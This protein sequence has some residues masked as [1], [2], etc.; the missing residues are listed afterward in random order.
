MRYSGMTLSHQYGGKTYNLQQVS[1]RTAKKAYDEG[2]IVFLQ[3]CNMRFGNMWQ[4]PCP[5]KKE[6]T[7]Y[8]NAPSFESIVAD[9][10]WYN[11]DNERGLYPQYFIEI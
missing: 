2:K 9:F 11:C 4:T 1:R 8:T 3:S 6:G 10:R 5:I 7:Q